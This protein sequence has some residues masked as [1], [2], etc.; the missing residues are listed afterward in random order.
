[1]HLEGHDMVVVIRLTLALDYVFDIAAK[2]LQLAL[3]RLA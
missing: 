1:M 3:D 2:Q